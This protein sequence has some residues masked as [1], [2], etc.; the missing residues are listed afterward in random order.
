MEYYT[1]KYKIGP[2]W[3]NKERITQALIWPF[4]VVIFLIEFYKNL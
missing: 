4:A 2:A 3:I 1:T